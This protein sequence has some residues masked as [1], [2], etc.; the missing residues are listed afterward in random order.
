MDEHEVNM[1][2]LL[3]C[4][5]KM[6]VISTMTYL[7]T[8][9]FYSRFYGYFMEENLTIEQPLKDHVPRVMIGQPSDVDVSKNLTNVWC[10]LVFSDGVRKIGRSK[11]QASLPRGSGPQKTN[12]KIPL[13]SC[14]WRIPVKCIWRTRW[15]ED[16]GVK[17]KRYCDV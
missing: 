7:I 16:A 3:S 11:F 9:H 1:P 12:K 6:Y 17:S 2:F 8:L 10:N 13:S 14:T 15:Q 4:I 5:C